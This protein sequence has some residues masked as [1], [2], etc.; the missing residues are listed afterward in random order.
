[1]SAGRTRS[2]RERG[3]DLRYNME[4]RLE[5]AYSGKNR[6]DSHSNFSHLRILLRLGRENRHPTRR[7]VQ[8]AAD[9]AASAMPRASSPWSELVQAVRAEVR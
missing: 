3:A 9:R 7:R 2:G 8:P 1:M 4:I 5:E 6:A